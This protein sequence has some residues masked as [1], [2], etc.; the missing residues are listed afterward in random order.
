M[1]KRQ[2]LACMFTVL[3]LMYIGPSTAATLSFSPVSSEV[4]LGNTVDVDVVI[5]DLFDDFL[6]AQNLVGG[7]DFTVGYDASIIANTGV[8]FS[9]ALGIAGIETIAISDNLFP[10]QVSAF[11]V[12]FLFD[13]ELAAI[14]TTPSFT[15]A[16]L[17]FQGLQIGTSP[18]DFLFTLVSDDLGDEIASMGISGEVTVVPLPGAVWLMITGLLGI[19]AMARRRKAAA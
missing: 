12:S 11:N 14:Q 15:L 16:T 3:G 10:G 18:L 2:I 7:F 4:G 17:S 5:S 13:F 19:G 1:L 8:T 9:D 6:G